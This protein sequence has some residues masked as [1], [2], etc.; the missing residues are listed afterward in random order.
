LVPKIPTIPHIRLDAFLP[1]S[2]GLSSPGKR[3]E[4]KTHFGA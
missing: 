2:Y 3:M 1:I 4:I